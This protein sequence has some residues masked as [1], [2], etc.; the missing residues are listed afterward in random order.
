MTLESG[1]IV[2][3]VGG[4]YKHRF[5][6]VCELR[7]KVSVQVQLQNPMQYVTIRRYNVQSYSDVEGM[8]ES[9]HSKF[10]NIKQNTKRKLSENEAQ[11]EVDHL[12]QE[13]TEQIEKLN[14]K[15]EE[16]LRKYIFI[17]IN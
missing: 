6:G 9:V 3:V 10:F 2:K 4:K 8:P 15:V 7:G 16:L 11:H 12:I 5:G 13:L 14:V 1:V 17:K